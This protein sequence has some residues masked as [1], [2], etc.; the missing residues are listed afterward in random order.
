MESNV[1]VVVVSGAI[2]S[3]AILPPMAPGAC[4]GPNQNNDQL[5]AGEFLVNI[6]DGSTEAAAQAGD[7]A[8]S[9]T[10]VQ[11]NICYF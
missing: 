6:I 10:V 5:V 11:V 9:G 4:A 1:V 8:M 7:E 2:V 3:A